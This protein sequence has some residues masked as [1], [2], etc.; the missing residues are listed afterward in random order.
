MMLEWEPAVRGQVQGEGGNKQVV[1]FSMITEILNKKVNTNEVMTLFFY[2]EGLCCFLH[3]HSGLCS[4]VCLCPMFCLSASIS[5]FI[6]L[7]VCR[8]L[9]K[10]MLCIPCLFS[11]DFPLN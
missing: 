2:L 6:H 9:P 8:I 1:A 10:L 4:Y 7:V 5:V 3:H 11:S